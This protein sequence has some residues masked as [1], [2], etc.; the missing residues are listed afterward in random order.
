MGTMLHLKQRWREALV[1]FLR[2]GA[3]VK[4]LLQMSAADVQMVKQAFGDCYRGWLLTNRHP[5]KWWYKTYSALVSYDKKDLVANLVLAM[6][7]K[8]LAFLW[9][10]WRCRVS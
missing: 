9:D 6:L 1:W 10:E 4:M 2:V 5:R 3:K 7:K 8:T